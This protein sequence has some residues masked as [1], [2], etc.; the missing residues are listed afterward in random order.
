MKPSRLRSSAVAAV[1]LHVKEYISA[2]QPKN[3]DRKV[4]CST[5]QDNMTNATNA[6]DTAAADGDNGIK[7]YPI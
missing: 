6:V 4:W 7:L 2:F 5:A 3:E 1:K